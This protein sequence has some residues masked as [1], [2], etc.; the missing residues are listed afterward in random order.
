[1]VTYADLF[2]SVSSTLLLL[3]CVTRSSRVE[4][5]ATTTN[6]DG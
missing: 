2:C 6:S 1:M 3:A 4:I 5:A